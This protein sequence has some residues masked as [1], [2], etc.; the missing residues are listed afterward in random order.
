MLYFS[1]CCVSWSLYTVSNSEVRRCLC[2]MYVYRVTRHEDRNQLKMKICLVSVTSSSLIFKNMSNSEVAE[3]GRRIDISGVTR[4]EL[5]QC[6]SWAWTCMQSVQA[7]RFEHHVG[8]NCL[9]KILA[10]MNTMY[11]TCLKCETRDPEKRGVIA[12]SEI[13]DVRQCN[14]LFVC[15][16]ARKWIIVQGWTCCRTSFWTG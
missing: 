9:R 1:V 14:V 2:R 7:H 8:T 6:E 12:K 4:H 16:V 15:L 11:T 5:C 10:D 13:T 3:C